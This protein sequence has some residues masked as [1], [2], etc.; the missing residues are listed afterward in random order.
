M[1]CSLGLSTYKMTLRHILTFYKM[2]SDDWKSH[3]KVTAFPLSLKQ[4]RLGR[5]VLRFEEIT[6]AHADE[7]KALLGAQENALPQ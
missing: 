1:T 2:I 4:S 5:E 7:T 6:K 3:Y